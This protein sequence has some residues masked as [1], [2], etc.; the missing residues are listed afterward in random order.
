MSRQIFVYLMLSILVVIFSK[1]FHLLIIYI[2]T[3]F[4]WANLKLSPVFSS[5]GWGLIIRKTLV[6][7]ILPIVI[8]AIPALVWRAVRGH[9]MPHFIYTTWVVW[10]II[11][12]SDILIR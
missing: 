9:E 1:Y 5:T 2:D 7:M 11:V 10:T 12:L 6:L 3:F 4:T 8:T